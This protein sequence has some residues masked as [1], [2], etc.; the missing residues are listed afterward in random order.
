MARATYA[1]GTP[2]P[3]PPELWSG[4]EG[5]GHFSASPQ[6]YPN[7]CYIAEVE[8]D[9]D[10]G[11]V[12]LDAVTA[13]DDVGNVIN[14]L[15]LEG[16]IHGGIAQAA[17]QVLK[18]AVVYAPDGQLLTGSF[19]D[20]AM[21]HAADFPRFRSALRPVPTRPTRWASRAARR[22]ARSAC[23]PPS[24]PPSST[25]CARWACATSTAPPRRMVGVASHPGSP[26]M[27]LYMVYRLDRDD[28]QAA[29]IRAATR[30]RPIAPTWT[31]SPRA[32]AWAAPF[33]MRE[34]QGCGG[35]MLI[36]AESE[37]AVREMVR[38]DPFEHGRAVGPH[39]HLPVPL[40][41]QPA[42]GPAAPVTVRARGIPWN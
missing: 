3:L 18:E 11:E 13:V 14:P 34:G 6:N 29:A 8:V 32:C 25:R 33:S 1:W 20:Y 31:S 37:E 36:E 23:R 39:R 16:Q 27:N 12:R 40:A 26:R 9:P 19:T 41:D 5:V 35:L 7:G 42:G 10:T 15:L 28:G 2:K 4:L 38:N 21:P 24:S 30:A 22:P 17:G